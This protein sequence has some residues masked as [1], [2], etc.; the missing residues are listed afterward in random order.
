MSPEAKASTR[1]RTEVLSRLGHDVAVQLKDDAPD[2]LV[3]IIDVKVRVWAF[4]AWLSH[5]ILTQI[6][7]KM[8][9]RTRV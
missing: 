7:D 4:C 9:Q 5:A 6:P 8:L 1:A 3:A 2:R